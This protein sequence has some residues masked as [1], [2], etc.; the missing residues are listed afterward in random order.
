MN[1]TPRVDMYYDVKKEYCPKS[2][3]PTSLALDTSSGTNGT[4]LCTMLLWHGWW[5][6]LGWRQGAK[7][8]EPSTPPLH[9]ALTR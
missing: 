6:L 4:Q 5:W 3:T 7:E 2:V 8:K 1:P 9:K